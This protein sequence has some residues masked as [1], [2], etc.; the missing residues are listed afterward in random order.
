MR[1]KIKRIGGSYGILFDAP[2]RAFTGLQAG[3]RVNVVVRAGGV[4]VLT[5]V[6]TTERGKKLRR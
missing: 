6:K 5:P 4:M 3:D 1:T 2:M